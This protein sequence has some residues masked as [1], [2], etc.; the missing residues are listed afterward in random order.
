LLILRNASAYMGSRLE[1]GFMPVFSADG[2]DSDA[3]SDA[4]RAVTGNAQTG[5]AAQTAQGNYP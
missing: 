2:L 1:T 3:F 5:C 4:V